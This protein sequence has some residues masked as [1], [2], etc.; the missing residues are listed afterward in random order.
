MIGI[1]QTS[2]P[3]GSL[4]TPSSLN[5]AT[6]QFYL[7]LIEL[8]RGNTEEALKLANTAATTDAFITRWLLDR[9]LAIGIHIIFI[10]ERAG[11]VYNKK[12]KKFIFNR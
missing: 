2:R 12:E 8:K 3:T 11:M 6:K 4:A 9:P 10:L 1:S 5:N 7:A